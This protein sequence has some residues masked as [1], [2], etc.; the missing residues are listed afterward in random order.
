LSSELLGSVTIGTP[1]WLTASRDLTLMAYVPGESVEARMPDGPS[2]EYID[3]GPDPQRVDAGW[4]KR[5]QSGEW[6]Y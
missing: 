6:P 2:M 5:V 3:P 4:L 1:E